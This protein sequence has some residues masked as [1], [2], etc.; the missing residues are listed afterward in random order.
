MSVLEKLLI[1]I[2]LIVLIGALVLETAPASSVRTFGL[3]F[4]ASLVTLLL[5][6]FVARYLQKRSRPPRD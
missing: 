6:G 3:W 4:G 1:P 2:F 5:A